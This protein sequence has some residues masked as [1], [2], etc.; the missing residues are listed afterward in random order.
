MAKSLP[1]RRKI[2]DVDNVI[3]VASGKGG[4]GKSTTSGMNTLKEILFQLMFYVFV[5]GWLFILEMFNLLIF[6]LSQAL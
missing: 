5:F 4:V 2:Q 3:V 1:K 6:L